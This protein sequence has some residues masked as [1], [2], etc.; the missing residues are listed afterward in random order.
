MCDSTCKKSIIILQSTVQIQLTAVY[1]VPSSHYNYFP[2][3]FP[4]LPTSF[5]PPP[6]SS[7]LSL[8]YTTFSIRFWYERQSQFTPDQLVQLKKTS[9]SKV[10]CDN[11]DNIRQVPMDAFTLQ[12]QLVGCDSLPRANLQLWKECE[13]VYKCC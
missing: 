6:N 13:G 12:S 9:L 10:I 4:P 11:G 2:P 1:H 8:F 5:P 7:S 3:S